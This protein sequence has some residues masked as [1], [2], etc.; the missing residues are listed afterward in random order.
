MSGFFDR[1]FHAAAPPIDPAAF[2]RLN[3]VSP[4]RGEHDVAHGDDPDK[5]T[6]ICRE[7]IV[8][9]AERVVGHE[10]MLKKT[11]AERIHVGHAMRRLYDQALISQLLALPL[12]ELHGHRFALL[13]L[14]AEHILDDDN[15]QRLAYQHC[16]LIL[17]FGDKAVTTEI[18]EQVLRLRQLVLRFGVLAH[19]C[20]QPGVTD[21]APEVDFVVI[22]MQEEL[23]FSHLILFVL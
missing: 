12:G 4:L 10:F 5:N 7:T 15:I 9:R 3:L 14:D 17:R 19:E 2:D 16:L 21:L 13:H 11:I 22:D 1:L 8:N 23:V 20:L 18:Y 6:I